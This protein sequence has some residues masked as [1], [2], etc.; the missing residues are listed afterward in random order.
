M[1][2]S[3]VLDTNWKASSIA[4][5]VIFNPLRMHSI[6]S[7]CVRVSVCVSVA[8]LATPML[9][10]RTQTWYQ[11]K[12][13]RIHRIFDSWILRKALCLKVMPSFTPPI[14]TAIHDTL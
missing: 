5:P 2:A 6:V 4:F 7:L 11:W 3:Q 14:D 12:Q 13:Y 1:V 8:V 10:Y 9:S